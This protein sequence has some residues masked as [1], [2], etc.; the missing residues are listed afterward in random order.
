MD[1][2]Q[3]GKTKNGRLVVPGYPEKDEDR[4]GIE[5]LTDERSVRIRKA[6]E[7]TEGEIREMMKAFGVAR[8]IITYRSNRRVNIQ[9]P[10]MTISQ[11]R[12]LLKF[13]EE[14]MPELLREFQSKRRSKP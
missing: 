8:G 13:L 14:K 11:A 7:E 10:S 1:T 5:G 2:S 6:R 12:K 9:W 4:R 3:I